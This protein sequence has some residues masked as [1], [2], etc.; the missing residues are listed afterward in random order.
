[1][2]QSEN[3]RAN[4]PETLVILTYFHSSPYDVFRFQSFNGI[5]LITKLI[6]PVRFF[7]LPKNFDLRQNS[8][9]CGNDLSRVSCKQ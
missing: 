1:M 4:S 9:Y 7:F 2:K 3:Q 5:I 6:I 8:G